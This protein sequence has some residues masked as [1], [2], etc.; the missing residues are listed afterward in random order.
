[1]SNNN[2]SLKSFNTCKNNKPSINIIFVHHGLSSFIKADLL[3]LK[4]KYHVID[5]Y[6]KLDKNPIN[7]FLEQFKLL[8]FLLKNI[9]KTDLI[10]TWFGDYH[11]FTTGLVVK[12]FNKKHIISIAGFDG[13]SIPA[14]SFGLFYK[15]NI[16]SKLVLTAYR[17][18]DKILSV[19][20]SLIKGENTYI[21]G[22]NIIGIG[23]IDPSLISKSKVVVFGYDPDYWNC[24]TN[25]KKNQI[26]TV[27]LANNDTVAIRKGFDIIVGCAK[28]LPMYKFIYI[29]LA[30]EG[31]SIE[32][33]DIPN[34]LVIEKTSQDTLRNYFCESKIFA[35]FSV[36]E[37]LPNTLCES[38][39]CECIAV[40]SNVNGI[41]SVIANNK[42]ILKEK[43]IDK[44]VD[45]IKYAM[46]ADPSIGKRNRTRIIENYSTSSRTQQI[47][48]LIV[49]LIKE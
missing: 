1:M 40:G 25:Y 20:E 27:G 4:E 8:F 10:Y 22:D 44:A 14:I 17:W 24:T 35:Q 49:D 2:L 11:A 39:L 31:I 12:L 9:T 21:K 6:I 42:L 43:D 23:N 48:E 30:K 33:Q 15:K 13:V 34:L 36:S 41:P 16:R 46:E 5:Y 32:Y 47:Q 7:F 3:I 26:L 28:L 19:D 38:M 45:I 37:G 29:G 18:A